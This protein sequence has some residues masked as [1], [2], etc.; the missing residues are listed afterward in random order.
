MRSIYKLAMVGAALVA[1]SAYAD[2]L[3]PNSGNGEL[4]LFVRNNTTGAVYARGLVLTVD[5]IL[6]QAEIQAG[7]YTGPVQSM[8]YSL[9]APIGPDANLTGFLAAGNDFSWTVM[10]GDSTS[11]P[12]NTA[13][14]LGGRRYVVTT[15]QDLAEFQGQIPNNSN[16]NS[17]YGNLQTMLVDLNGALPDGSGT[18]TPVDGLWGNPGTP[19]DA[20]QDWFGAG[21]PDANPLG[22]AAHLY[23]FSSVTGVNASL[24]RVYEGL[25]LRL[26]STGTLESV[27]VPSV[28]LP[29]ALWLLGSALV[30][31][32]GVARRRNAGASGTELAAVPA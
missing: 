3:L 6:T 5:D 28:P 18:S 12:V 8:G 19:Y 7:A 10:A 23:L 13:G 22:A 29:P 32:T 9:P 31:V 16:L 4:T 14:A 25:N 21:L 20:D 15:Q 24:A 26:T 27:G 2:V 11:T 17:L 30:G 1:S